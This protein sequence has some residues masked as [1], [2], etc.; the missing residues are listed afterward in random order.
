MTGGNARFFCEISNNDE[1][2]EA[3]DFAEKENLLFFVIGN[4]SNLLISD[5]GF[6]GL[7]IKIN[8]KGIKIES[9]N[10][11]E[12]IVSAGA[13]ESWDDFV[14]F[15]LG[16]NLSGT[17]N[18]SGIPSSVGAVPVQNIGAYGVEAKD[19]IVSV[20]GVDSVSLESFLIKNQDCNFGYRDSIFK[21]NK[22]LVITKV[23]F[24]LKKVFVPKIEY[25]DL[26]KTFQDAGNLSSLIVS[27]AIIKIRNNKLPDTH[28][29]GTAGSYFKNPVIMLEKYLEIIK[30]Y[31]ELPKF[32]AQDGFVKIPLGFVLDKICELRGFRKGDVGLYEKQALVVVN[33][34]KATSFEI[35]SF[36]DF[37]EKKV[38][39]KIGIKIESE[40]ERVGF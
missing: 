40:V 4:G 2:K 18:L 17:E 15:S 13:G 8:T 35:N 36:A 37:I 21:K 38:F 32:T 1:L 39:E 23:Y 6:D 5:S 11:E 14:K 34:G 33:F 27:E 29:V 24:G 9:E 3:L 26:K 16:K 30:K 19:I 10:S 20:E 31:P 22:N 7:I 25:P 12:V 28:K